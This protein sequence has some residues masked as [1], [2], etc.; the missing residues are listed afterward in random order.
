MSEKLDWD[1]DVGELRLGAIAQVSLKVTDMGRAEQFYRDTLGLPHLFT[2]GDLAFFDMAGVRLYLQAVAHEAW[3]AGSILYFVVQDIRA[4]RKELVARD[5]EFSDEPHV[6]YTH[7][8]GL[9]EWMTFFADPDGN[10]LALTSRV[11]PG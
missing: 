2:A 3:R 11:R 6:I 4:A 7:P 8:D 9:A 5:V 10:Q 1:R